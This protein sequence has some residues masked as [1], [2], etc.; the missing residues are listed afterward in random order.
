MRAPLL[1]LPM[2]LVAC[3]EKKPPKAAPVQIDLTALYLE[4]VPEVV[5]HMSVVRPDRTWAG[6]A[7]VT[8]K[9]EKAPL[10]IEA[11]DLDL[12]EIYEIRLEAESPATYSQ[13]V[14]TIAADTGTF[15]RA[16]DRMSF[17]LDRA[18][19]TEIPLHLD[20]VVDPSPD[21]AP[22]PDD[23]MRPGTTLYYGVSFDDTPITQVVPMALTVRVGAGSDGSRMLSWKA[24]IDP[25]KQL[26]V[27][28]DRVKSG[29]RQVPAEQVAEG[30]THSDA[31]L[32]GNDIA[33]ATS[34][35]VSRKALADLKGL[36]GA[37]FHDTEVGPQG[38]LVR[39]A[40]LAV[41][42]QAD[43]GLW[44]IET[45]VAFTHGGDGVYVIADD[46]EHPLLVSATRPG[47][48]MKLLAIGRPPT[49]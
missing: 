6:P 11:E 7:R 44:T 45:L 2:V 28:Y 12:A 3:G 46:P 29:R 20:L 31:F 23:W 30:V 13:V 26:D 41:T 21:I 15:A 32:R 9:E 8:I 37:A 10:V 33:E 1:L 38:V 18:L 27:T 25:H 47:Y 14:G 36:G 5:G 35:F 48:Q 40:P 19:P 24:D 49:R 4:P 42:V 17:S 16:E 39:Q 34:I 22:R 43:D